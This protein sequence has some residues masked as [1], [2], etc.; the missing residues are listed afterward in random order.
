M[1]TVHK[2]FKRISK[3][4]SIEWEANTNF[5]QHGETGYLDMKTGARV[6]LIIRVPVPSIDFV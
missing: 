5:R 6:R 2:Q 4:L 3:K 1:T